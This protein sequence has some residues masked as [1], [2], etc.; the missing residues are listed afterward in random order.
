VAQGLDAGGIG[1]G[2]ADRPAALT[3]VAN[4]AAAKAAMTASG[5]RVAGVIADLTVPGIDVTVSGA[6]KAGQVTSTRTCIGGL[7]SKAQLMRDHGLCAAL[8]KKMFQKPITIRV[9]MIGSAPGLS[10]ATIQYSTRFT[11][12]H[13]QRTA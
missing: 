5:I 2:K 4:G 10:D 7:T 8:V 3:M 1:S 12:D 9:G 6:S 11:G 13:R